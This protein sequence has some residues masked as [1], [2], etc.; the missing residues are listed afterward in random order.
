MLMWKALHKSIHIELVVHS[1]LLLLRASR[2]KE[3]LIGIEQA[4]EAPDKGR[5]DLIR[6]ESSLTNQADLGCTAVVDSQL[7]LRAFV[8][9]F[10]RTVI[11]DGTD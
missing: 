3:L 1:R 6:V 5:T 10:F 2:D 9:A 7:A 11:T 8:H 4:G